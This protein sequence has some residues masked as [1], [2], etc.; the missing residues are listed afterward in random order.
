MKANLMKTAVAV[1]ATVPLA[2]AITPEQM[3]AAPRRSTVIPSPS[4]DIGVFSSTTYDWDE[5]KSSTVWNTLNLTSGEISTLFN[6]SDISEFLFVGP[7]ATSILYLNGTNEEEDGGVSLYAGDIDSF[8]EAYLVASFPAPYSGLKAT[9]TSSGDIHFVFN[10]EAYP[11]GTAYNEDLAEEPRS[12]ARIYDS[13]YVRHWDVWRSERRKNVFSGVLSG[14]GDG[15]SLS[16][17]LTNLVTGLESVTKAE[18]PSVFGDD[19]SEYDISPDGAWVVFNT[20]NINLPESNFTSSQIYLVPYNRSSEPVPINAIGVLSTPAEVEGGTAGPTFSPDSTRIAYLQQDE[21][22]YESDRYKIY[23]AEVAADDFNIT[24]LAED[25]DRS[26]DHI[27][28]TEDGSSLFVSAADQGTSRVFEIPLSA[29]PSFVPTAISGNGTVAGFDLLPDGNILISDSK[30]WSSR[31]VYVISPNGT[32]VADLLRANEIDEELAGLGPQ[33]VTQIFTQGSIDTVQSWVVTPT[34]FDPEKRYPLAYIVHGGPQSAHMN[35]WSTRWNFKVWAD[36][37]YVVVAPNPV[38]SSS[39]GEA[40]QDAIQNN[41]GTYPYEDLVA[42]WE[43]VD[44]NLPFV[45]TDNGIEAGASYGGFMTNWI[46][47]HD[48]GR[49]FKALVTHDGVTNTVGNYATEELWF[50]QRDFNGTL[51]DN[52]DNYER[53]NPINHIANWSTPHF[54]IHNDLDFRLPVSEGIFLFNVLQERGVPSRFLNFPDENHWVLNRENSLVW[55][56]EIFN[57]I[58]YWSGVSNVTSP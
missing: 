42:V 12:S 19:S 28:W 49:K 44:A 58:N 9:T 50:M 46:Q 25:W 39:F 24:V 1:L 40:F 10:A 33:D 45:D 54:V 48:L 15:F 41:W 18:S 3:L 8:D 38:G 32:L 36:Q 57:W 52:R 5:H 21:I 30:I 17:N 29:G 20:K 11:N 22:F 35:S 4:G 43:Y 23:I 7:N 53:F 56:T 47:G 37:G 13:I 31:D 6:G 14:G 51:W 2:H 34:G 26:P 55:H 27:V 16:G